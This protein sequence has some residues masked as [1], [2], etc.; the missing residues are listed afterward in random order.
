M[1]SLSSDINYVVST[2]VEELDNDNK[3]FYQHVQTYI[4]ITNEEE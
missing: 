4:L 3:Q 2:Y 1:V